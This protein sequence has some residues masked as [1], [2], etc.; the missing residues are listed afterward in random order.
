MRICTNRSRNKSS[1]LRYISVRSRQILKSDIFNLFTALN[2]LVLCIIKKLNIMW[3]ETDCNK[4][5]AASACAVR[6]ETSNVEKVDIYY[7]QF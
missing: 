5:V 3:D 7:N 1:K 6:L 4:C 2:K